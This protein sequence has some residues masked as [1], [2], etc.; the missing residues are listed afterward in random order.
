MNGRACLF[1]AAAFATPLREARSRHTLTHPPPN[2]GKLC[3]RKRYASCSTTTTMPTNPASYVTA[4]LMS[5]L[6]G[7]SS[8]TTTAM[9]NTSAAGSGG[10]AEYAST[11]GASAGGTGAAE[12]RSQGGVAGEATAPKCTTN[13]DCPQLLCSA[14]WCSI[15]CV[16]GRCVSSS[17]SGAAGA[18]GTAPNSGEAGSTPSGGSRAPSVDGGDAPDAEALSCGAKTCGSSQ[19]C[20]VPCCGGSPG[21]TC[22]GPAPYCLDIPPAC[23]RGSDQLPIDSNGSLPS[24]VPLSSCFAPDVTGRTIR[25]RCF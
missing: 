9:P 25:C 16:E 4:A 12:T 5:W 19:W 20:V 8:A 2:P 6:M 21:F 23:T 14:P 3:D 11:G 17:L 10:A 13:A 7:C 15:E 1:A 22:P 18:G 24:C